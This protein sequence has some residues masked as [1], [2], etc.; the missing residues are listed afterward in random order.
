MEEEQ[1]TASPAAKVVAPKKPIVIIVIGMAGG[2]PKSTFLS[3]L[4]FFLPFKQNSRFFKEEGT[5]QTC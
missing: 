4:L 5:I 1:E 2:N 3:F